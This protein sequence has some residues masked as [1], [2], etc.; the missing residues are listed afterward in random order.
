[1]LKEGEE[2]S[3]V[4]N[5]SQYCHASCIRDEGFKEISLNPRHLL[6]SCKNDI[7]NSGYVTSTA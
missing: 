6:Y 5:L 4:L 1:M 2:Q 7:C 3:V